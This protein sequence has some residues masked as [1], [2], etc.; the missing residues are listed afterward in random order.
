MYICECEIGL[1]HFIFTLMKTNNY[2]SMCRF[3]TFDK[4]TNTP[5][6]QLSLFSALFRS[7]ISQS[8][9]ITS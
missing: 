6:P 9:A 7:D 8:T 1:L 2:I 3:I 5:C 4:I